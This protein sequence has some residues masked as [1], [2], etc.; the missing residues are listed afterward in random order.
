M[1]SHEADTVNRITRNVEPGAKIR[2]IYYTNGMDEDS[3][4]IEYGEAFR[5][6]GNT[7]LEDRFLDDGDYVEFITFKDTRG[8]EYYTPAVRFTVRGGRI[9]DMIVV[10]DIQVITTAE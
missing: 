9:T 7:K 10:D 5:Y 1:V 6:K 4:T 2:P 8:D 3:Y